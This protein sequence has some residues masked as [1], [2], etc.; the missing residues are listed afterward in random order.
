MT[1]ASPWSL[2]EALKVGDGGS[3]NDGDN[4]AGLQSVLVDC[5]LPISTGPRRTAI[6]VV[7]NVQ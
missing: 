3:N 5:G 7:A 1:T 2:Q 6:Y 4:R